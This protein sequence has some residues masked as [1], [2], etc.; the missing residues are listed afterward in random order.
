M[1][2]KIICMRTNHI[3]LEEKAN[4]GEPCR[5][6]PDTGRDC[7]EGQRCIMN[8]GPCGGTCTK[9]TFDKISKHGK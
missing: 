1:R 5:P 9:D 4:C 2:F 3:D 7:P 8:F 6:N